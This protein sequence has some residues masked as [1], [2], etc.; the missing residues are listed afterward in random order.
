M[1]DIIDCVRK[2]LKHSLNVSKLDFLAERI[3]SLAFDVI[4]HVLETGPGWRLVSP[5]FS[6]L[7]ESAIFP[8]LVMNEKDM[9]E[10]EEDP[11]E[12]IR[13]NL[14][15]DLEEISG[16]R[17]DLFTARKS[18]INLLGVI[19]LSK[20]PHVAT[21]NSSSAASKRKKG[22]RNKGKDQRCMGELVVLPF[23]S[24]FPVPSDV[25]ASETKIINDYYGV[26]MAFGGLQDFLDQQNAEYRTNLVHA[27]VLPLYAVSASPPYLLATAN[28]LLGE[29]A[30]CLPEE[31]TADV[32]SSL[33]K[34]LAMRD[35][36]DMSCY[37]VRASAA[38]AISALFDNDY[39][40][41]EW[42]PFLQVV[43]GLIGE[44]DEEASM[45]FQ[46][47]STAVG[48]GD[49]NLAI[50]IPHL[51]SSLVGAISE[52][53]P[54]AMEPWP[55]I[56]VRG[57]EALAAMVQSWDDCTSEENEQN[58]S[59][60]KQLSGWHTVA[61]AFSHLLQWAWL[62][63]LQPLEFNIC[64]DQVSPS[65]VLSS[66]LEYSSTLLRFVMRSI[67][68]I[69]MLLELKVSELLVVW[70]EL[71]ADWDAWEE[72][73]DL[74]IFECIKEVVNLHQKYGIKNFFVRAMP[75]APAPPVSQ[76]SIVEGI[77]SFVSKAISQYP[78]ATW[79]ASSCVHILLHV[80]NYSFE[81]GVKQSLVTAF[82]QAA[83]A[84]FREI[85][86]KPCSLW[87]PS[88]LVISSC[89]LCY[90]D[91][92]ERIL[93]KDGHKGFE[94][95]ASALTVISNSTFEHGLS[96]ESEIKL[97]VLALAKV[98][99]L[100]L[101]QGKLDSNLYRDCFTSLLELYA[102]LKEVQEEE[103]EDEDDDEEDEDDEGSG[104]ED[105]DDDD[106]DSEDDELEETEEE[107]LNRYA[108]AAVALENGSDVEEGDLGDHDEQLELGEMAAVDLQS[109]LLTVME[110]YR[111]I[112]IQKQ[113][114]PPHL[115]SRF[116]NNFPEYNLFFQLPQ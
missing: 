66:C 69:S 34:A 111:H 35:T 85:R 116:L 42:P 108:E 28:W 114:P 12:Y 54:P 104:D 71:I 93:E 79:R 84:R 10:W 107:F 49:K 57:F 26:L 41:P 50:H 76:C 112:L 32:Y 72:K 25:N 23:L 105:T 16:W 99:E 102:R 37:I 86:S 21:S 45:L 47:L 51:I 2:L 55:E 63:P 88:L 3:I 18:A 110:G 48:S 52:R 92:V 77:G 40:P 91:V 61:R 39:L 13:K 9:L 100:L 87:K 65:L 4:S 98:V 90:P 27:R 83:F 62:T 6:L 11:D 8:A 60:E 74:S 30:P 44:K 53:L 59:S 96:G 80:P 78:S 14:P 109:I 89:Y 31:L 81:T 68:K 73:E 29:L 94:V 19:S 15:C 7:L 46:L 58:E 103:V 36:D 70:A 115:S 24:K 113:L 101:G 20:G 43:V 33:L 67:T 106:E 97:S 82:T 17:E 1:P 95:W 5:H 64:E 75:S 38:G 56:V 22:E